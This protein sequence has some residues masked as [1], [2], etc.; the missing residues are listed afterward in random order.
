MEVTVIGQPEVIMDAPGSKHGYFGWPT[1]VRLKNGKIAVVASGF[2]LGHICPFGK[3]VIAYSNNEGRSYTYPAPVIDTVLD[4]RDGGIAAFG[5]S[6]VII[7]SFNLSIAFHRRCVGN[8]AYSLAYLNTV[9][10]EEEKTALGSMFRL[11]YDNGVTFGPIYKSPITSPHGPVALPD[12]TLLWV[13]TTYSCDD[14][15]V[16]GVNNIQAY[17]IHLD[18]RMTY[19]GEIA[20]PVHGDLNPRPCEPHTVV[21]QDGTILTHIRV[22]HT[23]ELFTLYQS[24]SFDCGNSWTKPHQILADRGGAP[25]HLLCHSSG[26]LIATYGF[27]GD[28][29]YTAPYGIRVMFSMDRGKTWEVDREIYQNQ[30]SFDLGYPSTVELHDG[31]LLTVFYATPAVG[32]PAVI[33]QQKWR[34]NN[35][36]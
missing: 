6:G 12:G 24:E 13:G 18:G 22:Q 8:N 3:T 30:V 21:L 25:S 27:R 19:V 35:E 28:P 5:D 32:Q 15:R 29:L 31:S 34:M 16:M 23:A 4:D 20:N 10:Q 26:V 36:I 7:T 2:R 14:T 9:T 33:M 1:A 17:R 11:S